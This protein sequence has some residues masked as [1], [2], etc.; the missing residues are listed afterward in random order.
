LE[1]LG[2]VIHAQAG[3]VLVGTLVIV[4]GEQTTKIGRIDEACLGDLG[5]ALQLEEMFF[6][7][8]AAALVGFE[9]EG[10]DGAR[11]SGT[12][13]NFEDH[14]LDEDGADAIA[15][16]GGAEAGADEFVEEREDFMG[17]VGLDELAG[18]GGWGAQEARGGGADEIDE[19][20]NE[21]AIG[22]VVDVEGD[23]GAIGED[24]AGHEGM[25]GSA[26]GER[27]FATGDELDGVIGEV[28]AVDAVIGI[29][30]F[31]AA[32]DDEEMAGGWRVEVE[33]EPAGL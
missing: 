3:E 6:D 15:E 18:G 19:V 31:G 11:E 9:G 23:A 10:S 1:A 26:K 21:G 4:T 28:G 22:I 5:E 2:G 12:F 14:V 30:L 33:V 25:A 32:A 7:A 8:G 13:G 29:T 24:D 27:A 17:G 16:G 20:F